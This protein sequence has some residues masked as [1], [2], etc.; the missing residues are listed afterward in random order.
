ML[1]KTTL[2]NK[3]ELAFE[4]LNDKETSEILFGGGAGGG[5]SFFLCS[6]LI[7]HCLTYTFLDKFLREKNNL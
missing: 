2:T 5:K 4:Y 6:A 1:I 3:Q 7:S